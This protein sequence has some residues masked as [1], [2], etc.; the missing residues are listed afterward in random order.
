MGTIKAVC[1]SG[2][3]GTAKRNVGECRL[4]ENWG[5][6]DDAHAGKW[7]RQVSLL[8]FEAVEAFRARG[9]AID[10]GAFGENLLVEGY[11]FKALP[12]G[13][14][15]R[16]GEAVLEM[17]Q[18]GKKC[19]SECGIFRQA[20]DCIMPREGVFAVVLRGGTVR[21]GEELTLVKPNGYTAAV[22]TASDKGSRGEREDLSGPA[23]AACLKGFGYAVKSVTVLPDDA[24]ALYREMVRLVDQEKVDTVFTTGG[25]GFSTR[26]NTP[27]ATLRAA[28]RQAPGIAQAMLYNSL[29]I[30]PRAMLSRAVSVIRGRSL[31]VNLPGSPKAVRECLD[32]L[33]PTLSHGMGIM[34]GREGECGNDH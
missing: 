14:V 28:T 21:V 24:E 2:Q 16:C 1:I 27:E 30:T 6:E 19:H 13:T 5:L 12:V 31:I 29:R 22:I 8:S 32:Y 25:T 15:F 18:I 10:D 11:D 20:G 34:T 17:T 23:A 9:V 7:H 3:K 33:L 26:D 4:I